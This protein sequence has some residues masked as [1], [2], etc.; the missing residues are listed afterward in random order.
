MKI[1]ILGSGGAFDVKEGCSSFIVN[2][3]GKNFLVDCG[4]DVFK[5]LIERDLADKIDCVLISH[6]NGDHIGSLSTY[7]YYCFY[8]LN[9]TMAIHASESVKFSLSKILPYMGNNNKTRLGV[10]DYR[11][12][13]YSG[14]KDIMPS[15]IETDDLHIKNMASCGFNFDDKLIISGD[16]GCPLPDLDRYLKIGATVLHDASTFKSPVHCF[17]EDLIK[18]K[19]EKLVTYH[20]GKGAA[21]TIMASGLESAGSFSAIEIF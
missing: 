21:K 2:H 4:E 19:N 12:V 8:V 6:T 1:K 10:K 17:Y 3:K 14:V 11:F 7:L 20:H 15:C 9:K 18:Y 5:K 13:S 16:I